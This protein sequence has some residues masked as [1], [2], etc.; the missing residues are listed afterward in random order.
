[1]SNQACVPSYLGN[2]KASPLRWRYCSS[3]IISELQSIV[4]D[5]T[6]KNTYRY[7]QAFDFIDSPGQLD[8]RPVLSVLNCEQDV[9]VICQVLPIGLASVCILLK[10]IKV[11]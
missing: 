4:L 5:S 3:S 2:R 6:N 8:F 9:E 1:M 11:T 7:K 10:F